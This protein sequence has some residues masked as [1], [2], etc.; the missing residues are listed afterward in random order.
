MK[1][2]S[3]DN[4]L[5]ISKYQYE[6]NNDAI[7]TLDEETKKDENSHDEYDNINC[8]GQLKDRSKLRA[9]RIVVCRK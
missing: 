5:T 9:Y 7:H 6:E 8:G 2:T 3:R 4:K 1:L